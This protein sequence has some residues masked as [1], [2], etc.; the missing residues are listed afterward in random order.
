M[1]NVPRVIN[2]ASSVLLKSAPYPVRSL[3]FIANLDFIGIFQGLK[4]I[5]TESVNF[6]LWGLYHGIGIAAVNVYQ[7]WKRQIR[8]AFALKYFASRLSYA[9]GVVLTFNFFA[10]GLLF[11]V[12]SRQVAKVVQRF[13]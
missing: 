12:D 2:L 5:V 7:K 11:L 1:A 4:D 9:V 10:L 6:I 3:I 13:F 8:N